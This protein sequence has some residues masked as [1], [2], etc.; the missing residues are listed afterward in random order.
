MAHQ[1]GFA[2]EDEANFISYLACKN[3]PDISFQYSGYLD[4]LR[5]VMD[6]LY[7][8]DKSKYNDLK[9]KYSQGMTNDLH[10]V[11]QFWRNYS[12]SIVA[13]TT[14]KMNDTYLKLNRQ[15]DG[16]HSYGR[17]V[18]LLIAEYRKNEN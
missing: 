2:R 7:R 3:H 4:A 6:Q 1:R 10:A 9:K 15:K 17:V 16:I 14:Y 13:K 8:Y 12:G 18:D 11:Y 5:Q